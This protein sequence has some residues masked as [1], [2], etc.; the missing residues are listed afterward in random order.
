MRYEILTWFKHYIMCTFIKTYFTVC[1]TIQYVPFYISIKINLIQLKQINEMKWKMNLIICNIKFLFTVC[2]THKYNIHTHRYACI[3]RNK[4]WIN[5]TILGVFAPISCI[6]NRKYFSFSLHT[7][8]LTYT[9]WCY[10]KIN[11]C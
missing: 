2:L 4:I 5:N 7:L 11:P 3:A 9:L 8:H 10:T 1:I 6:G